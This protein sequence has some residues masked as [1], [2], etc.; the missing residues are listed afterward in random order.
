M[1]GVGDGAAG[2]DFFISYTKADQRWAEWVAWQ[3]E[4]ADYRV[5]IQAWDFVP[6]SDWRFKMEQ[7]VT[8]AARTIAVLSKTYLSSVYGGEEWRAARAADPEGL[9]RKLL[10][11]RVENCDRPGVL[12][13]VVSV[14]L[15]GVAPHTARLR[16]LAGVRGAL[17]GRVKPEAEP[18]FP[19]G[20]CHDFRVS[21]R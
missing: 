20:A 18:E 19:V 4:A 6:G 11:V 15:F 9:A 1:S 10:P 7:G 13:T 14:D 2:W 17:N 3:L 8:Q 5:L 12:R 16:L 21:Q